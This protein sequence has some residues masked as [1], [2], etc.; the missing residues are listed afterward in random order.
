MKTTASAR[1]G[2]LRRVLAVMAVA[3]TALLALPAQAHKASDAYLQVTAREDG[4]QVRW[5]IALRDLDAALSLDE[6]GNRTLTSGELRAALPRVEA[7]V[8]P[9]L[10]IDGCALA[11]TGRALETRSDGTYLALAMEATCT[12]PPRLALRYT[13][14]A[15][16]D[17]TRRRLEVGCMIACG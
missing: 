12:P 8:V 9:H 1:L 4:V 3:V 17:A 15:D 2:N 16:I 7:F 14:F 6:D 13:L 11:P 10:R 5:D